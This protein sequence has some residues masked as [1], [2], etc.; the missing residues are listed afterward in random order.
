LSSKTPQNAWI[1]VLFIHKKTSLV[2]LTPKHSSYINILEFATG[3]PFYF[4]NYVLEYSET[5]I[6]RQKWAGAVSLVCKSN[7][8]SSLHKPACPWRAYTL[9]VRFT[10]N[11]EN[12]ARNS[13]SSRF[14]PA[15]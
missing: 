12:A 10:T 11:G 7:S 2:S 14:S 5:N 3:K 6:F 4:G 1:E 15:C 8:S 9:Q 13:K